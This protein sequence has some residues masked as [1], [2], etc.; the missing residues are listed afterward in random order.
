[1]VAANEKAQHRTS[2]GVV[3]NNNINGS[4]NLWGKIFGR[5]QKPSAADRR[6][7]RYDCASVGTLS[8][9]NRSIIL[10]GIV[11]EISKSGIKFRP[12]KTYLLERTGVQVS[13]EFAGIRTVG[14]IAASRPDGY[15]VALFEEIANETIE[16]IVRIQS[17]IL[18]SMHQ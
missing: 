5:E 7:V 15:G 18:E 13:I 11:T 10:E 9:A 4:Q 14:K 12:T 16:E 1:M 8:I 6:H 17:S 2:E 3:S